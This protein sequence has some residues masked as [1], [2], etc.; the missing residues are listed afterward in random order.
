[1]SNQETKRDRKARLAAETE[2]RERMKARKATEWLAII[3]AI[4]DLVT[5]VQV[6]GIIWWE[7]LPED[8]PAP[9]WK[10]IE[11]HFRKFDFAN[12]AKL[13]RVRYEL[14]R[15]GYLEHKADLRV[16]TLKEMSVFANQRRTA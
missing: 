2:W 13:H 15:A 9:E 10:A 5:R 14:I 1:M 4:P 3:D 6:A 11:K 16:K 12:R 7:W 8:N